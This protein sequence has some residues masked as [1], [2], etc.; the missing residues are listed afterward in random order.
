MNYSSTELIANVGSLLEKMKEKKQ[1]FELIGNDIL[2]YRKLATLDKISYL[3]SEYY[4]IDEKVFSID[5]LKCN[6]LRDFYNEIGK[7]LVEDDKWGK[8]WNA[9][10]DILRG[11]FGKTQYLEPIIN[12]VYLQ[13]CWRTQEV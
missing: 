13:L 6:S 10:I 12:P 9:F 7:L 2:K 4:S 11:G 3:P 1:I 8:N 5:G